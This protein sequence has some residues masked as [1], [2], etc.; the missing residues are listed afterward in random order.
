[1]STTIIPLTP[2]LNIEFYGFKV[3]SII[4]SICK[5]AVFILIDFI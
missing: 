2:H 4:L 5:Y 1:M 3:F